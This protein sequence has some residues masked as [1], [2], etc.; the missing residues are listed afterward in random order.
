MRS[1]AILWGMAVL[2]TATAWASPEVDNPYVTD[3]EMAKSMDGKH[4]FS[5]VPLA[6]E[7]GLRATGD[8]CTDPLLISI[9]AA[10]PY[11]DANQTNCGRGNTYADT[12]LGSYDGGEDI[13]YAITVTEDVCVDVVLSSTST[14]KGIAIDDQ[15]PLSAGLTE[16][17]YKGTTSGTA[18]VTLSNV[19]L[20]AAVGTYYV[21]IDTYPSPDCIPSFTLTIT[22]CPTLGACCKLDGTCEELTEAECLA[23]P[24]YY[25][26]EGLGTE[27]ATTVCTGACCYADGSC[28][29]DPEAVC[30]GAGGTWQGLGTDCATTICPLPPVDC[31]NPTPVTDA[32]SVLDDSTCGRGYNYSDTCLGSYDSGEDMIYEWTITADGCYDILLDPKGTTYSGVAVDSVCPLDAG[33]TDCLYKSTNAGSAAHGFRAEL[34]AGIYYIMVDTY[35]SPDCIPAFDLTATPCPTLGACCKTDGTCEDLTEAACL[36]DPNYLEYAGLGT[37]CATTVCTGAC[38]DA[39]G[40]CTEGSQADCVLAGGTW[41]GIGT[42]CDP[43]PCPPVNDNCSGAIAVSDGTPAATGYNCAAGVDEV[44]ASCQSNSNKDIWYAYTATCTGMVSVDTEGSTSTDTVLSAYDACAGTEIACDDDSGSGNLSLLTFNGTLGT[45]YY[46]RAASYSTGCG[47]INVN[48]SCA[49]LGACCKTDG[50]CEDTTE[51]DCLADPDYLTFAGLGTECATTA[52]TGA[53]CITGGDCLDGSYADCVSTNGFWMGIDTE[54]ATTTCPLNPVDCSNPTPVTDLFSVLDDTTCER[55]NFYNNTCMGNY[56]NG[57]DMIYEWTVTAD[58]VYDVLLDPKGTTYS[59]VAL[60]TVCP[61]DAGDAD[62]LYKSVAG[63]S[64]TPHG[65]RAVLSAGTYYIMVDTWP[66]PACIPAFDLTVTAGPTHGAC[67]KLDGTCADLTEPECLADPNYY[68]FEGYGSECATTV[69]TGAC[70]KTDGTCADLM[71]PACLADPNYYSF[72]GQGSECATTVCTGACCYA[73]GSCTDDSEAVCVGAGGTWQGLGTDCATTVCPMPPVDCTNPTPVTDAFSVLDDSTCGRLNSY[74]GTCLDYYD[75]GEDMIYEWTITADGC[76]DIL[77]DPK[78]STYTGVA[79]DTVCPLD[80]G[81]DDCLYKSTASGGTAHGFRASLTAGTYYI[82]VDTFPSPNCIPSYD[83]TAVPCPTGACCASDACSILDEPACVAIGGLYLGDNTVCGP[84]CDNDGNP[85]ACEIALGAPDCQPNGI[86]DE[87]DVAPGGGSQDCQP[88]TI[89]DECELGDP[90]AYL[91]EGFEGGVIP[92]A[93]WTR[94]PTN[95]DFTWKLHTLNPQAGLYATDVE[96]DEDLVPQDE[97][98][99]TPTITLSGSVTLTGWSNGSVYWGVTPYDNYDLEAWIVVGAIGGGDDILLGKI[100]QDTWVINWEWAPFTYVFTA[101]AVP[102][103]IGF[104]YVGVDG[105]Q[106]VLDSIQIDDPAGRLANDCNLNDI[107][108]DCDAEGDMN[109]DGTVDIADY[110][111]FEACLAGPGAPMP[112]CCGLADMDDDNDCDLD[113]FASYQQAF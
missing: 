66:S 10:L 86:P 98:L 1:K 4:E 30:V 64:S 105:A 91:G 74:S 76:Y 21:M 12:C 39:A 5:F 109:G 6:P 92:P 20:Y 14:W 9:P 33:A 110:P 95:V 42:D 45:T 43:N 79:I 112:A 82:M 55:G 48:I 52:C 84:D 50:I 71:E 2:C 97:W 31:T 108:D 61:L 34:T 11:T 22:P 81:T 96:F 17:L 29:D 111:D 99:L 68:S 106:A 36:A 28:T 57:E 37:A 18:D 72:E 51:A 15:C 104:R 27:C 89:P 90:V 70:C 80:A 88:N 67:C 65:F 32:F 24:N 38:C 69:C 83:L 46:I 103:S 8:D 16:C 78:G 59:G 60:D 87:C 19:M 94:V 85:D 62:C 13:I 75:G 101:P 53:C 44:E 58:G 54:C 107:P 26:F 93:G 56:D 102:F 7:G 113:D 73:D 25:S 63:S 41:Q 49:S 77:L 35:A 23:D 40:V 100:D 47:D 3:R